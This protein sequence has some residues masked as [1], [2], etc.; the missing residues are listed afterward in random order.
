MFDET[1][2]QSRRV[3]ING[4]TCIHHNGVSLILRF[5]PLYTH[6]NC[7]GVLQ[8]PRVSCLMRQHRDVL[9]CCGLRLNIDRAKIE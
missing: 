8:R 6:G 3:A 7:S 4:R 9:M 5:I 2:I 1:L